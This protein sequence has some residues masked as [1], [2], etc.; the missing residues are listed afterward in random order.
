[1]PKKFNVHQ[2]LNPDLVNGDHSKILTTKN[3]SLKE[4]ED[5]ASEKEAEKQKLRQDILQMVDLSTEDVYTLANFSFII[6]HFS[7]QCKSHDGKVVPA[8][9]AM[10]GISMNQGINGEFHAFLE[11]GDIPLGYTSECMVKARKTH[12]IPTDA[13]DGLYTLDATV[14]NQVLGLISKHSI[15]GSP[16]IGKIYLYNKFPCLSVCLFVPPHVRPPS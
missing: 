12:Q 4:A 7:T 15:E 8:E 9:G 2:F 14:F 5:E 6:A 3:R 13:E 16:P 10:M 11:P 1:M